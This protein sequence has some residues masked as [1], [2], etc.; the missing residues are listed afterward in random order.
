[1]Q[2]PTDFF[3]I[4]TR[5]RVYI[6]GLRPNARASEIRV[7]L[8]EALEKQETDPIAALALALGTNTLWQDNDSDSRAMARLSIEAAEISTHCLREAFG[9]SKSRMPV[10]T[11]QDAPLTEVLFAAGF[12]A[13]NLQL[14]KGYPEC[15]CEAG[16]KLWETTVD[17]ASKLGPAQRFAMTGPLRLCIEGFQ[18]ERLFDPD[19]V[20]AFRE[21]SWGDMDR[22]F[23]IIMQRFFSGSL[24]PVAT[25]S[26]PVSTR[27]TKMPAQ[28]RAGGQK[29]LTS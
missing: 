3:P 2:A 7:V 21:D 27:P 18:I 12:L 1:M 10:E 26:E 23:Q 25:I 14:M 5:T 22:E 20:Q 16:K 29:I 17:I 8:R 11:V 19:A 24:A 4:I 15:V 13:I 28:L 9:G 6:N